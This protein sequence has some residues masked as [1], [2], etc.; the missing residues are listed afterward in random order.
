MERVKYWLPNSCHPSI[1]AFRK[2]YA[3]EKHVPGV[4][5]CGLVHTERRVEKKPSKMNGKMFFGCSLFPNGC[6]YLDASD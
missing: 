2:K 1:I 3:S 6:S 5:H 4:C